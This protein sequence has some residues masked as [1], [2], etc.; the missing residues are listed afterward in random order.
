MPFLFRGAVLLL[1][2]ALLLVVAGCDRDGLPPLVEVTEISPRALEVGDRVEIR[3]A[4]FPQGRVARITFKGSLLRPGRAETSGSI[5][6]DGMVTST[7]RIEVIVTDAVEEGFCGHGDRAA[8]TTMNGDVEVAFTSS[9]PGAAPLVGVMHGVSLDV[10]PSSVR[11]S[12]LE[13]RATEGMRVLTYL[14]ITP[15]PASARGIPIDKLDAGSPGER[16]GFQVGDV[17]AGV[18]GVHVREVADVT[19]ASA[20][21]A[22]ITIRHGESGSEETKTVPMVG[23]ASERIPV[24]YAPALLVV[25]VALAVLVLLVLPAPLLASELEQRMARR[26]R[27]TRAQALLL[28]VVGR[29]PRA[30]LS[31]LASILVATFALGPHVVAPDLDGAVLLVA[32]LA[33]LVTARVS[34]ARGFVASLRAAADA[35]IFSI[36][37]VASFAGDVVHTGA[38]RLLELVKAQGAWPW[39]FAAARH[40]AAFVLALTALGALAA[41][42]RA[43]EEAPKLEGARV[44]DLAVAKPSTELPG[45]RMLERL[46]LFVASALV[47]AIF[48]GGWQLPGAADGPTSPLTRE[49][50]SAV[51]FVLK[52]WTLAASVLGLASLA[53][54]WTLREAR[55]FALRRLLPALAASAALVAAFRHV[56]PSDT[57]ELAA[58]A[59]VVT[60]FALLALRTALRVRAALGRPEPHASPFL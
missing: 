44:D 48:F 8:H 42:V 39:E 56:T 35:A 53:T 13:A 37:L 38:F 57:L 60:A 58:G 54:P 27:R 55:A 49:I 4:G 19:P 45:A 51:V 21:S 34:A 9:M 1:S 22:K 16:A 59:T 12:V 23:Y 25:G 7:D 18:D 6:A 15:G 33:L 11:S 28:A 32:A 47:V 36:A 43:R 3:G 17:V 30:I 5:R 46:G 2:L 40:P 10:V 50:A 24:E 52:T 20:R 31:V 41:L 26:L 14:G 29:G